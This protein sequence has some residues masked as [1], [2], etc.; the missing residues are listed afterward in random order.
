MAGVRACGGGGV[1]SGSRRRCRLLPL[2]HGLENRLCPRGD[3]MWLCDTGVPGEKGNESVTV[4]SV[5]QA[6]SLP[7][8]HTHSFLLILTSSK[9]FSL[10]VDR[11][12]TSGWAMAEERGDINL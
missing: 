5:W 10:Y 6:G 9:P 3:F 12:Q 4:A 11:K 2:E 1:S 7:L 8:T